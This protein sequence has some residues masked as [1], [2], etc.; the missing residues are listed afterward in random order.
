[1]TVFTVKEDTLELLLAGSA[2]TLTG[3]AL[4]YATY[5]QKMDSVLAVLGPLLFV[6][7]SVTFSIG[8]K[9]LISNLITGSDKSGTE[10]N[11]EKVVH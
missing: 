10:S 4:T 5:I 9:N 8:L 1:M 7:G 6:M 11:S 3:S 2:A